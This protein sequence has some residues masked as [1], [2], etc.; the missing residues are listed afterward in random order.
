MLYIFL[1]FLP[2][3]ILIIKAQD[4]FKFLCKRQFLMSEIVNE[5]WKA[6]EGKHDSI[7]R[8]LYDILIVISS[9]MTKEA[10]ATL[11]KKLKSIDF[12]NYNELILNLL[13]EFCEN[14]VNLTENSKFIF[15]NIEIGEDFIEEHF[16]GVNILWT[17]ILDENPL[18][19]TLNEE[20]L[21][22]FKNLIFNSNFRPLRKYYLMKSIKEI[23]KGSSIPQSIFIIMKIIQTNYSKKID[24]ETQIK[25]LLFSYEKNFSL[26]TLIMRDLVRYFNK[27][28]TTKQ[29]IYN[30]SSSIFDEYFEGKHSHK[31]N[32]EM[33]LSLLEYF[34]SH[35]LLDENH[36][37]TLWEIF[38]LNAMSYQESVM[39]F[40][41]LAK[42]NEN[43][44]GEFQ[45]ILN[46]KA[47]IFYQFRKIL[48]DPA[49][50]SFKNM[51]EESFN[52][53]YLF[54][55]M[56]NGYERVLRFNKNGKLVISSQHFQ[57][58][59]VLWQI[60]NENENDKVIEKCADLLTDL[61]LR[62]SSQNPLEERQKKKET[63][64]KFTTYV[65]DLIKNA[66][67]QSNKLMINKSVYLLI[68]FFEKFE[69]KFFKSTSKATNNYYH[70]L[71]AT[72]ILKPENIQKEIRINIY[73]QIGNFRKKI[74]EEFEIPLNQIRLMRKSDGVGDSDDDEMT[75][76]EFGL[77]GVYL[78]CKKKN[79]N[80][81]NY[82]PK[83]L[84]SESQEY[85]DLLFR[86]L[87]DSQAGYF[88]NN[89]L[90]YIKYN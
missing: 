43:A 53:F 74:S 24:N 36:L 31:R 88:S 10:L 60:F 83:H 80:E 21:L 46:N 49:K 38:V 84:I 65:M 69:G 3:I 12:K 37:E 54:F 1:F 23:E 87:S 85:L 25:S 17:L 62:I 52:L 40:K 73:D 56:V 66:Y 81:E 86:L 13:K 32:I 16:F 89:Y 41:W 75:L 44:K 67:N 28:K 47:L 9:N 55:L 2:L 5:I 51:R 30:H 29:E 19:P 20:A 7:T 11:Y 61:H 45:I 18:S 22:I 71:N 77:G 64:E 42:Q 59:N 82:H 68:M 58:L 6:C 34:V 57:G 8:T 27:I 79:D 50:N 70:F 4:L 39:Y 63:A 35:N 15:E 78:I 90:K 14:V 72:V 26:L 48:C 76:R 33:R